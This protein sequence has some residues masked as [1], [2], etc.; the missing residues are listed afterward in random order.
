MAIKITIEVETV[1]ELVL[2]KRIYDGERD[3]LRDEL[4]LLK[5]EP[6]KFS[7]ANL[8]R[9]VGDEMHSLTPD[10]RE[11]VTELIEAGVK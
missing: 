2:V 11:Q 7:L 4:N 3:S 6:L 5:H 9:Q 8:A 1:Q 10:Q